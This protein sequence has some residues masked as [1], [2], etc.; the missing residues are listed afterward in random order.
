[1]QTPGNYTTVTAYNSDG[2]QNLRHRRLAAS[3]RP[4]RLASPPTATTPNG[5]QTT[6]QD[7]RS[8]TTT[9]AYNADDKATL[10]TDPNGNATLTCYDGDGNIAQTIPQAGVAR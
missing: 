3:A 5:N 1:M 7:A 8:Y 10:V 4:S 9:T 2:Q 6:V